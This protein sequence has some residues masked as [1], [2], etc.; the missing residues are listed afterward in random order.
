MA[1]DGQCLCGAHQYQIERKFLNAMHCYC[2]M[3]RKAHG[4]AY[5]THVIVR[6]SELVWRTDQHALVQFASSASGFREV[7]NACGTHMLVHGQSGDGNLAIPAGTVNGKPDVTILGHMFVAELVP[8]HHI[9]DTLPQYAQW[10]P[11]YGPAAPT[12]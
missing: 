4:T 11:G 8:W 9:E 3:C 7:C 5:S 6:P 12:D 1:F 2:E 10:P